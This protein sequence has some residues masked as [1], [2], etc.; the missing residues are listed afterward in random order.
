MYRRL[1][2]GARTSL[3]RPRRRRTFRIEALGDLALPNALRG[4]FEQ[5]PDDRRFAFID[6]LFDVRAFAIGADNFDVVVSEASAARDMAGA[7]MP[8]HRIGDALTRL[9]ALEFV[10]E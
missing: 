3:L 6:P 4:Q 2:P 9:L 7:S 5:P 10:G 1:H 8:H